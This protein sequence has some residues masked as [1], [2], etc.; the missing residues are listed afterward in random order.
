VSDAVGTAITAGFRALLVTYRG[1][2]ATGCTPLR[3]L[4]KASSAKLPL[5][6]L[7]TWPAWEQPK[8]HRFRKPSFTIV[9]QALRHFGTYHSQ[10]VLT[11]RGDRVFCL[12]MKLLFFYSNRL[13]GYGLEKELE[14][15]LSEGGSP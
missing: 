11:R 2:P 13:R 5:P 6:P 10:P 3:T 7:F 4:P 9:Q 12:D 1:E 15:V 14:Q 8:F